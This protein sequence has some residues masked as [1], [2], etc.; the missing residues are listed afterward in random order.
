[1]GNLKP[2]ERHEDPDSRGFGPHPFFMMQT[3]RYLT[4]S[5][6][7][8]FHVISNNPNRVAHGISLHHLEE[9]VYKIKIF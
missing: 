8:A 4:S 2:W 9:R 6:T 7:T 1:M 5:A 3:A